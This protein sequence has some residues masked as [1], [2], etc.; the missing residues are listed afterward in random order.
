MLQK[1]D[2]LKS[3]EFHFSDSFTQDLDSENLKQKLI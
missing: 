1:R 2:I 3:E